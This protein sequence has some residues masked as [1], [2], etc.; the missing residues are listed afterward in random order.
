M[1]TTI[2]DIN[3]F[4]V[5]GSKREI[6]T[7]EYC[8]KQSNP[9]YKPGCDC[10]KVIEL[11]GELNCIKCKKSYSLCMSI[12]EY[13]KGSIAKGDKEYTFMNYESYFKKTM[14]EPCSSCSM[15]YKQEYTD[16]KYEMHKWLD[17]YIEKYGY[18]DAYY[19]LYDDDYDEPC[20]SGYTMCPCC[21]DCP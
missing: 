15:Q 12:Y 3:D 2:E 1:F 20:R 8:G 4:V 21:G 16:L 7:C 9:A 6:K 14:H 5:V 19:D 17:R 13:K 18:P 10:K 11:Y